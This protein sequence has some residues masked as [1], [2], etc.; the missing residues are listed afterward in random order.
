VS[1][2]D[3][4][5]EGDLERFGGLEPALGRWIE[6]ELGRSITRCT[7]MPTGGSRTTWSIDLDPDSTPTGVVL[8]LE[9][10]GSFTGTELTLA[11]ETLVYQALGPTAVPVPAVLVAS[12]GGEAVVLER[13]AGSD[14]LETLSEDERSAV[15]DHFAEVLAG[16]HRVD[17][18]TLELPGFARPSTPE[19]HAR[20]DLAMWARLGASVTDLD[21]LIVYCGAWLVAHAPA[22]VAAT[23]LVQGDTGPGNFLALDGR[24]TGLVDM[25]FAHVGDP[26]DDLAW[27]LMRSSGV[28]DPEAF[29]AAYAAHGGA[30]VDR[31]SIDYYRLAVDYRCAVTTSLAVARGG[32]AR[33]W[34][35]YLL[36]TQRYLDGI[37]R[38]LAEA[39]G[40]EQPIVA[41]PLDAAGV[42]TAM[43]DRLLTTLREAS[44]G[45]E[46]VELRTATRNDQ[47]L[48][49]YLR[50]H[51]QF[52]DRVDADDRADRAATFGA[53][54]DDEQLAVAAGT[55][56]GAD[57]PVMLDY[58]LRRRARQRLLWRTLLDR[59]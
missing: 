41:Q 34:S 24:V 54:L 12:P 33:G 43:F 42:R 30:A 11:R 38:A 31:R 59:R 46:D 13:L 6:K 28:W 15:M 40:V 36:V 57:E 27:V 35:P 10:Q 23:A 18:D 7:R 53:E 45:I 22:S 56:V 32:G 39:A 58:L 50:A 3:P 19:D 49:H 9:G 55:A 47:I 52:G 25:E 20:L 16:L 44:R 5:G 51:A 29:L 17:P 48:V 1:V 14:D 4:V 2:D 8:R 26:M 21:P 37:A